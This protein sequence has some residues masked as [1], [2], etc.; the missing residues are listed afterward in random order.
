MLV[1]PLA[2]VA[3]GGS[4]KPASSSSALAAVE[5]AALKT[6]NAGSE[7][8]TLTAS[9]TTGGRKIALSGNGA[10]DTKNRRGTM[11]VDLSADTLTAALDEV[12]V[13]TD[14]YIRSPLL[15]AT[16]PPGK[17][18]LKID[19]AKAGKAAGFNLSLLA[20]QDPGQA[21]SY[22][23]SLKSVTV[24]GKETVGGVSTTH[25]HAI[26]PG[27]TTYDAW[28]GDD[29]YVHQVRVVTTSGAKVSAT[30]GLSD[31]GA[32]V[33]VTVPPASQSYATNSIPGL[34]G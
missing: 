3:C 26:A 34:G 7:H 19:L 23:R 32:A 12:L 14:A 13:G 20:S 31:F 18:W 24:V 25:F 1:L 22:L 17:K 6:V 5:A 28:V 27:A 11:H 30:T 10:F 15:A 29:G 8:V 33:H 9:A 21:L 4:K 2:L 16:L